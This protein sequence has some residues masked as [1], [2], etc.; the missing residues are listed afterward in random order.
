MDDLTMTRR[1]STRIERTQTVEEAMDAAMVRYVVDASE[2]WLWQG[3]VTNAGYGHVWA[4][5]RRILAH[6]VF[7]E[8]H[9]G[10]I[11]LGMELDHLCRVRRCVNP[12]HLEPVTTR[13]NI[14]RGSAPT[15][16]NARKT[17]CK[18]G[19]PLSGDNLYLNRGRRICVT[20]MR[21]RDRRWRQKQ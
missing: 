16:A 21:D 13:E 20:C 12:A 6:R 7:Y 2:C 11:P 15:A 3:V 4:K 9:V 8:R 17:H 10:A 5:G 18:R 14:L 19:H 1:R